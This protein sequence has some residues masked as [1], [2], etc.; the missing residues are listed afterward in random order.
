MI[1]KT[2]HLSIYSL[3]AK[4]AYQSKNQALRSREPLEKPRNILRLWFSAFWTF[5]NF[6]IDG[7]PFNTLLPLQ[8]R[9]DIYINLLYL[10]GSTFSFCEATTKTENVLYQ[11]MHQLRTKW[12]CLNKYTVFKAISTAQKH[13]WTLIKKISWY[14]F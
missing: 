7:G 1:W 9:Q 3:T 5:W 6:W 14:L 8:Y 13:G 10:H 12:F 2:S 11:M 4:H